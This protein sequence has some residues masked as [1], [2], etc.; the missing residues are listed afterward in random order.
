MFERN[1]QLVGTNT[2][3]TD[4]L[5]PPNTSTTQQGNIPAPRTH[6]AGANHD[7]TLRTTGAV[8]NICQSVPVDEISGVSDGVRRMQAGEVD[9][10]IETPL[11]EGRHGGWRNTFNRMISSFRGRASNPDDTRGSADHLDDVPLAD[12]LTSA[13][14]DVE[15]YSFHLSR[16]SDWKSLVETEAVIVFKM[17]EALH[18]RASE[19]SDADIVRE[20]EAMT[21]QIR[22]ARD[23]WQA[24][25]NIG[26]RKR[27]G[28]CTRS[29]SI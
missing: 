8:D 25:I 23:S 11:G 28:C 18:A 20:S 12:L 4:M 5:N 15:R 22:Q 29:C 9:G 6:A 3:R 7:A 19:E 2:Q 24:C 21:N 10:M 13:R 1:T 16:R 26:S 17:L 14:H 27:S